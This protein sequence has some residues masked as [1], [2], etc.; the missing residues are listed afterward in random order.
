ML[1][2]FVA[3]IKRFV[4]FV[5]DGYKLVNVRVASL[6]TFMTDTA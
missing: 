1:S 3:I 4:Y 5:G 6:N 2:Y